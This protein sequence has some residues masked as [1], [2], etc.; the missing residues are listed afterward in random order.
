MQNKNFI[1]RISK[2]DDNYRK[3]LETLIFLMV[4]GLKN[5]GNNIIIPQQLT[6]MIKALTTQKKDKANK[7]AP[8]ADDKN[9]NAVQLFKQ[10]SGDGRFNNKK[11]DEIF[12]MLEQ[13]SQN[14][15]HPK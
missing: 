1:N 14:E 5:G 2:T 13:D 3:K 6:S 12:Q 8:A 10:S 11:I 9:S 15:E 7:Y 4:F